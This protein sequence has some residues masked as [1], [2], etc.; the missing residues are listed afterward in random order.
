MERCI[1]TNQLL[2][3]VDV[4]ITHEGPVAVSLFEDEIQFDDSGAAVMT[5]KVLDLARKALGREPA[6]A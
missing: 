6:N 2:P 3:D 1:I 5:P 4:T